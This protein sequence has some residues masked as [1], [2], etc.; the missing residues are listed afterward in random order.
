MGN[1][2]LR[3]ATIRSKKG[4]TLLQS[5][6]MLVAPNKETNLVSTFFSWR[7]ENELFL[8]EGST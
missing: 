7:K 3:L 1:P 5:S 4:E 8:E 6:V 2:N